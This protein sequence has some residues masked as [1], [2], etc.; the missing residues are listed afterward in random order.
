MDGAHCWRRLFCVWL[1]RKFEREIVWYKLLK[2]L[3]S[4]KDK[5]ES[6]WGKV[7]KLN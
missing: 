4:S 6:E 3:V 7:K 2:F 1:L 5:R